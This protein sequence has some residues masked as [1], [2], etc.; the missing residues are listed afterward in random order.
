MLRQYETMFILNPDLDQEVTQN[1]VEKFS[2]LLSNSAT[3]E[4]L[5]EIGKKRLAYPIDYK[6]EGYY[7]LAHFSSDP[8]FPKELERQFKITDGVIKYMVIKKN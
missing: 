3:L 1:L 8:N 5:E 7:I 4:S 6:T 2:G